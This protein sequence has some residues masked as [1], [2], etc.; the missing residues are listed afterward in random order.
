[1]H[2]EDESSKDINLY[3]ESIQI[4]YKGNFQV[5][6]RFYNKI[7]NFKKIINKAKFKLLSC[8]PNGIK[9]GELDMFIY[10]SL[11]KFFNFE[12]KRNRITVNILL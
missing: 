2:N 1:M 4:N 8:L 6:V 10:Y 12:D 3:K 5:V 7:H 11:I 9:N